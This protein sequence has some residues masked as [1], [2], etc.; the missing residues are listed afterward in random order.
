MSSGSPHMRDTVSSA[1]TR[2]PAL[3]RASTSGDPP[4][5][6]VQVGQWCLAV[7]GQPGRRLASGA[8][9]GHARSPAWLR[10]RG[11]PKGCAPRSVVSMPSVML[12][13]TARK[14][15]SLRAAASRAV[16][17]VRCRASMEAAS[18][19]TSSRI[20]GRLGGLGPCPGPAAQV[21]GSHRAQPA[22][23][24]DQAAG[25]HRL[26]DQHRD[27]GDQQDHQRV[28]GEGGDPLRGRSCCG[29]RAGP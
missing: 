21:V 27:D 10:R 29:R 28:A 4:D 3:R 12:S 8:V 24:G 11:W 13:I 2:C 17:P 15:A 1:E 19:S 26:V 16:L 5:Q 25:D 18:S 14:R 7:G 23:D 9:A 20:P 22:G 6:G